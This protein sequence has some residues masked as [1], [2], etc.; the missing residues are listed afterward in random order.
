M[1][2]K[3]NKEILNEVIKSDID[4][5]AVDNLLMSDDVNET[6]RRIVGLLQEEYKI[7]DIVNMDYID[8]KFIKQYGKDSERLLLAAKIT[9]IVD[10]YPGFRGEIYQFIRE[11]AGESGVKL[12]E[13]STRQG[14]VIKV[15]N[16]S[17][18][19]MENLNTIYYFALQP[20]FYDNK[21]TIFGNQTVAHFDGYLARKMTPRRR[22]LREPSGGFSKLARAT[23]N[24]VTN[25]AS[26]IN[27]F[28]SDQ[29]TDD[30]IGMSSVLNDIGKIGNVINK[31][32]GRDK[33]ISLFSRYMS[34]WIYLNE[35]NEFMIHQDYLPEYDKEGNPTGLNKHYNP[36]LLK[37]YTPPNKKKGD[38]YIKLSNQ[39]KLEFLKLSKDAKKITDKLFKYMKEE[40][41]KSVDLLMDTLIDAF[42]SKIDANTLKMIFFKGYS[43]VKNP[44]TGEVTNLLEK[45]T[46]KDLE[47]YNQLKDVFAYSINDDFVITTGGKGFTMDAL[48]DDILFKQRYWPILY[49]QSRFPDILNLAIQETDSKVRELTDIIQEGETVDGKA[50][51]PEG[52]KKASKVLKDQLSKLRHLKIVR[53]R[54]VGMKVDRANNSEVPF[55]FVSDNKYFKSVS[56]AFDIHQMRVDESVFNDYTKASMTAI[57]RNILAAELVNTLVTSKKSNT[58]NMHVAVSN[59]ALNL[60]KVIFNDPTVEGAF[61]RGPLKGILGS[62]EKLNNALNIRPFRNK[63]TEQTQNTLNNI[64]GAI[65]GL[66]LGG[67]G[68]TLQ[69]K[70]D[71][72]RNIQDSGFKQYSK[73]VS[74]LR[75]NNITKKK[76]EDIIQMSGILD[77]SDFFSQAMV[78]GIVG[79]QLEEQ[80]SFAIIKE[81]IDYHYKIKRGTKASQARKEFED[82]IRIY[83]EQSTAF[84]TAEDFVI[85]DL[86]ESKAAKYQN[87]QNRVTTRVNRL[88]EHAIR[89]KYVVAPILKKRKAYTFWQQLRADMK[90]KPIQLIGKGIETWNNFLGEF[91]MDETEKHI[92]SVSFAIGAQMAQNAGMLHADVD[93]YDLDVNR[94]KA[95][96]RVDSNGKKTIITRPLNAKEKELELQDINTII[97]WGKERNIKTNFA[98]S[99]Q[100]AGQ[101][102]Y[103]EIGKLWG[104]FKN[105]SSQKFGSDVRKFIN[106]HYSYRNRDKTYKTMVNKPSLKMLK[107]VLIGPLNTVKLRQQNAAAASFVDFIRIQGLT[108]AIMDVGTV[109]TGPIGLG[110]RAFMFAFGGKALKG[111]T[112]DVLS[113]AFLPLLMLGKMFLGPDD[114][115]NEDWDRYLQYYLRKLPNLGFTAGWSQESI[116]AIINSYNGEKT[117]AQQNVFNLARPFIGGGT[118]LGDLVT[119][120]AWTLS[121]WLSEE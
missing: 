69:N 51:S 106:A 42:E 117:K 13:T 85:M 62:T 118:L 14:R 30:A 84:T 77:F 111:F 108:T 33:V 68:T 17:K 87:Q 56:N 38:M 41:G 65:T 67:L 121:D 45:F 40:M 79:V 104:T 39:Q 93:W 7:G 72:F 47:L 52:L 90:N 6:T 5:D 8:E 73:A 2:C 31:E 66:H 105:W 48:S 98:L 24:H 89:H 10:A 76:V 107:A 35:N 120:A 71:V 58:K 55:S 81:M 113:L 78:S 57:Q 1:S 101:A 18:L 63:T 46:P 37:D 53:K 103:G 88:V 59:A 20:K 19:S 97:Q 61:S 80:V 50:V 4:K 28:T 116:W 64:K 99:T 36:I 92:R 91:T 102:F 119:G 95:V 83:L 16:I 115:D 43:T 94:K 49:N 34:G 23:E 26:R 74:L 82:N 100:G 86:K 12:G 112:S 25:V 110:I 3:I 75:D 9:G 60:Y 15:M 27:K 22:A 32:T 109:M 44:I 11:I 96:E 70:I 21:K 29:V 114:E 54:I